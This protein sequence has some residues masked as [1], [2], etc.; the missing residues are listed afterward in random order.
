MERSQSKKGINCKFSTMWDSG[1]CKI[2]ETIKKI[3]GYCVLGE[4]AEHR[5]ILGQ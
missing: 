3:S 1:K 2:M 4:M 5:G